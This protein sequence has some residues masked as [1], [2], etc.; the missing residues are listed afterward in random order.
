MR[1]CRPRTVAALCGTDS[2]RDNLPLLE[3]CSDRVVRAIEEQDGCKCGPEYTHAWRRRHKKEYPMAVRE[4][5]DKHT[6]RLHQQ[7]LQVARAAAAEDSARPGSSRSRPHISP[8]SL[9]ACSL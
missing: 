8:A 6:E 1:W 5:R 7:I 3:L 9:L 4:Y 2:R